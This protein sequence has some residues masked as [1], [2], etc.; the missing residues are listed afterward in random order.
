MK[1]ATALFII[2][3]SAFISKSFAVDIAAG[4]VTY[5]WVSDS[6]Y[7]ITFKAYYECTSVTEP[8]TLPLCVVNTCTTISTTNTLTKFAV[9]NFPQPCP[10]YPN[11]CSTP[12]STL[13]GF[14]EVIY[15]TVV[16]L[17]SRC[18]DWRFSVAAGNRDAAANLASSS[19]YAEAS[20]NN[21][22]SYQG[23]SSP[24]Y[25]RVPFEFMCVNEPFTYNS[26]A[27]DPNGDSLITDIINVKT[28]T[29]CSLG[30]SV[31]FNAASPSFVIP[32]NPLQ[33]NNSTVCNNITGQIA[34]TPAQVGSS[35]MALRTREYRNGVLIGYT[36][37][38]LRFLVLPC[39]TPYNIVVSPWFNL[40]NIPTG[41]ACAGS[42]ISYSI[43][44]SA[45]DTN[46]VLSV[47]DNSTYSTPG[48]T[49]TYV[50]Q[51]T[52]S[53]L[54]IFSWPVPLSASGSLRNTIYTVKDATCQAPGIIKYKY[55]TIP[56]YVSPLAQTGTDTT[57]CQGQPY[58]LKG[59]NS[60]SII[61]G[62]PGSLSCTTCS[63]SVATP[64]ATT[65]YLSGV[66]GCPNL[67]D[68]VTINVKPLTTPT[69]SISALPGV[70]I[71]T[72][73]PVAF[74]A[75]MA[76]CANPAYQWK[77]N[78]LPIS[79]AVLP[80]YASSTLVNG[81]IIACQLTCNDTCPS[82]KVQTQQVTMI[83]TNG[84][85][86]ILSESDII[87]SPNPNN[88]IFTISTLADKADKYTLQ[89][90]NNLG[91]SVYNKTNIVLGNGNSKQID[92]SNL[93]AGIYALMLNETPYKITISK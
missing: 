29:G 90:Y 13:T 91:Q 4:E 93:P 65:T 63:A 27:I 50:N 70:S 39:S 71:S 38:D 54:V 44:V 62:P 89:V 87:V 23:N 31:T 67:R 17:S 64:T 16:T 79:G 11:K 58:L 14:K 7:R 51:N 12:T 47:T 3:L 46:A 82:P 41:Y 78:G 86:K 48:A 24:S 84:V 52:D 1:K 15:T 56:F 42:T 33:T 81:D 61:S 68:T 57:I 69:L 73:T 60:W 85:A 20:L 92:L 34:F 88:G 53:I 32:N 55:F 2:F 80:V 66:T 5:Q 21:T 35:V 72:G 75:T 18:A 40:I 59:G 22:G 77:K 83:V 6:T 10:G 74:T 25:N 19:F 28:N 8:N 26:I 30:S 36:T 37:R 49:V 76:N 45:T 43:Y 9:N